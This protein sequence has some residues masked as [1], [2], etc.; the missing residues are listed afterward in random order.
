MVSSLMPVSICSASLHNASVALNTKVW[1]VRCHGIKRCF[2]LQ[3][4]RHV[5]LCISGTRFADWECVGLLCSQSKCY[6]CQHSLRL[7]SFIINS[8]STYCRLCLTPWRRSI[9]AILFIIMH[10]QFSV[11]TG[12][13]PFMLFGNVITPHNCV[14][15]FFVWF[16]F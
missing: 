3:M 10:I 13:A 11:C 14:T 2:F 15:I 12:T 1:C 5:F 7:N 9:N 8:R 16:E 6:S 4:S